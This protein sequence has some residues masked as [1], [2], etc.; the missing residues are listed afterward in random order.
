MRANAPSLR[1]T[2]NLT[3]NIS[4]FRDRTNA[5]EEAE[6]LQRAAERGDQNAIEVLEHGSASTATGGYVF[7][8]TNKSGQVFCCKRGGSAKPAAVVNSQSPIHT[9]LYNKEKEELEIITST[10]FLLQYDVA[11]DGTLTNMRQ[12]KLDGGSP[13]DLTW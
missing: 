5:L 3:V 9:M 10:M 6:E 13:Q 12:S 4:V 7:F 2:P 8:V 11:V 1:L